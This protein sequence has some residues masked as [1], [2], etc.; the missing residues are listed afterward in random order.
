MALSYARPPE[1]LARE[2][3]EVAR[4]ALELIA[5]LTMPLNV[6][7]PSTFPKDQ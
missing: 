2:L 5:A 3:Q 4:D 1:T 6:E 7:L